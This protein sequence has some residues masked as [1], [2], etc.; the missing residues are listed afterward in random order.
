M[1]IVIHKE[2]NISLHISSVVVNSPV[3]YIGDQFEY[4]LGGYPPVKFLA[5]ISLN[6]SKCSSHISLILF[7]G[8]PVNHC[9]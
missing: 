1:I 9:S 4:H 5:W 6:R 3:P 8:H 7:Q 2:H